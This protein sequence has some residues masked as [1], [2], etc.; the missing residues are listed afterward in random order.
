ME[1]AENKE[2][3]KSISTIE[4]LTTGSIGSVETEK[5]AEPTFSGRKAK[6]A[7]PTK[8][9][10]DVSDA[11]DGVSRQRSRRTSR[12]RDASDAGDGVSKQ[13]SRRT[14]RKS[15]ASDAAKGASR[16]RSRSRFGSLLWR[17]QSSRDR[18]RSSIWRQQRN[19]REVTLEA[20]DVE[21]TRLKERVCNRVERVYFWF[22]PSH[23]TNPAKRKEQ[24]P[25]SKFIM[26]I[27]QRIIIGLS[28]KVS[29]V[30]EALGGTAEFVVDQLA[31]ADPGIATE[32]AVQGADLASFV[33][34]RSNRVLFAV[35][36]S[37]RVTRRACKGTLFT[38]MGG[39]QITCWILSLIMLMLF[40]MGVSIPVVLGSTTMGLATIISLSKLIVQLLSKR[41]CDFFNKGRLMIG[42][43]FFGAAD[44][45]EK[46]ASNADLSKEAGTDPAVPDVMRRTA[47]ELNASAHSPHVRRKFKEAVESTASELSTVGLGS[48]ATSVS[49]FV[50]ANTSVLQLSEWLALTN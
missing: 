33:I 19:G 40:I 49:A 12:K 39:I 6:M 30:K 17:R 22:F 28:L 43:L 20:L 3:E 26:S 15:D 41:I 42:K 24:S 8:R 50:A 36:D 45:L 11:G 48:A 38:C 9:K 37:I 32:A 35:L 5:L 13:R 10:R 25:L 14:S 27:W 29:Y 44:D 47:S 31:I 46:A 7:F 18:K 4:P 21:E 34:L 1:N 16:Q 23:Q 2:R